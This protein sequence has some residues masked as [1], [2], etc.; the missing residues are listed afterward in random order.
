VRSDITCFTVKD[1][2]AATESRTRGITVLNA[3]GNAFGEFGYYTDS[4]TSIK[5]FLGEI[6]DRDGMP[7]RKIR[8]SDL[9]FIEYSTHL[10]TDSRYHYYEPA[11]G[12]YPYTVE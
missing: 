1:P 12:S 8:R 11:F 7:V 9:R 10:S 2:A 5:T 4:Y 3:S 6:F